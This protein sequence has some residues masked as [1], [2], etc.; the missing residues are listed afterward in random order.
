MTENRGYK[1]E[2]DVSNRHTEQL[3]RK[4]VGAYRYTFNWAL[5]I[6]SD[7]NEQY[8]EDP[9][10]VRP[11]Y[12]SLA[13][14]WAATKPEWAWETEAKS[15]QHAIKDVFTALKNIG[16]GNGYPNF[17][18]KWDKKTAYLTNQS[19]KVLDSRH[20]RLSKVGVIRTKEGIP[21]NLNIRYATLTWYAGKWWISFCIEK[22]ITKSYEKDEVL[23]IDLGIKHIMTCSDGDVCDLPSKVKSLHAKERRQQKALARSKSNTANYIKKLNKLQKTRLK[24]NN[25]KLDVVHKFTT[26]KCKQYKTIVIESLNIQDMKEASIKPVRR[27]YNESSCM[28]LA[29]NCIKYKA[30]QLVEAPQEFPSTKRCSHCGHTKTEMQLSERVYKCE[31]CGAMIDRDI[32]A[33]LNL[34]YTPWVNRD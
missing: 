6:V 11:T 19:L 28:S 21:T 1:I 15:Q 9:S 20:I 33:A 24:M 25:I 17:K 4:T 34:S 26:K 12:L 7:K 16:H 3:L 18:K 22:D 5:R 14:E 30:Y 10:V 29:Q 2:L 8:K 32:N 13:K 31:H 27:V 23:G